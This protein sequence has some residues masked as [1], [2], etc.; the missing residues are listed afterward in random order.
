VPQSSSSLSVN[1]DN[2]IATM[3]DG[4]YRSDAYWLC[5][6]AAAATS[7]KRGRSGAAS[8]QVIAPTWPDHGKLNLYPCHSPRIVR[9]MEK[10]AFTNVG[11]PGLAR[12]P[13]NS[14]F[15]N[16]TAPNWPD[17]GNLNVYQCHR[18]K[19]PR[20]RKLNAYQCYR[21][22]LAGWKNSMLTPNVTTS[23]SAR[24]SKNSMFTKGH[25][26]EIGQSSETQCLPMSP[27]QLGQTR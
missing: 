7:E 20:P 23:N 9:I 17:V 5:M 19:L 4:R 13:K 21:S 3:L 16:V 1:P 12:A 18:S 15:T 6:T 11:A 26:L 14:M 24:A 8:I 22:E 2:T 27:P 25:P 10:S